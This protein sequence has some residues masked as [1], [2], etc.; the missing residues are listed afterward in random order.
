[1]PNGFAKARRLQAYLRYVE[2]HDHCSSHACTVWGSVLRSTGFTPYFAGWWEISLFRTQG[3]PAHLPRIPPTHQC[4]IA[5]L[6]LLCL[7]FGHSK[8]S[9]ARPRAFMRDRN[10]ETNPNAIFQDLRSFQANGVDVL[11]KPV[12]AEIIELRADDCSIVLARPIVLDPDLP[13][14]CEGHAIPVIHAEADVVWVENFDQVAVGRSVLHLKTSGTT[15][16][17]FQ[18][19]LVAWQKMWGSAQ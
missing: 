13:V 12:S 6:R 3:A 7:P 18:L 11:L 17:L 1:M 4:A 5:I 2:S 10:G 14:L 9:C 15:P 16:E 8:P 19:F